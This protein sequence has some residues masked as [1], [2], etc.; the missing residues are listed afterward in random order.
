MIEGRN[1]MIKWQTLWNE[2]ATEQRH[3]LYRSF[4][5]SLDIISLDHSLKASS[6]IQIPSLHYA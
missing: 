2:R 1:N 4:L 5:L 6:S 3:D